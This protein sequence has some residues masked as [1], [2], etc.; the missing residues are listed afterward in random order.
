MRR[1]LHRF[2][3][4]FNADNLQNCTGISVCFGTDSSE[5]NIKVF[6]SCEDSFGNICETEYDYVRVSK[7]ID[8]IYY[9]DSLLYAAIFSSPEI[10]SCN[11]AR[12]GKKIAELAEVY[13][14]KIEIVKMKNCNS[15][16]S[17]QL[18]TISTMAKN[19]DSSSKLLNTYQEAKTMDEIVCDEECKIY[20]PEKC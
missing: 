11:I 20:E 14:G 15:V 12:L 9:I 3:S 19:L 2:Y 4:Y 5:C 10:Y 13:K 7:G 8:D 6:G 16:I 18:E 17:S 1:T